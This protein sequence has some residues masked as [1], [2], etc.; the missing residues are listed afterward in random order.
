MMLVQILLCLL[1]G[2]ALWKIWRAFDGESRLIRYLVLAGFASRAIFGSILYWVSFLELPFARSLQLDYGLWFFALDGRTYFRAASDVAAA[3]PMAILLYPRT[4]ISA[5]YVQALSIFTYLFGNVASVG[6]LLNLFCYL[7]M[8]LIIVKWMKVAHASQVPGTVALAAITL[9]PSAMLWSMVP[10]KDTLFQ[11]LVVSI[12]AAGA[13]W[14]RGWRE[15]PR[16]GLILASAAIMAIG[17]FGIAGIRWYFSLM[18]V[19]A[20]GAFFVLTAITSQRKLPAIAAGLVTVFLLAQALLISASLYV[21]R[22]VAYAIAPWK[23]PG[24]ALETVTVARLRDDLNGAR[25]GFEELGGAT[26]IGIGGSLQRIDHGRTLIPA[27]APVTE[28]D[29]ARLAAASAMPAPAP[30]EPPVEVAEPAEDPPPVVTT[31]IAAEIPPTPPPVTVSAAPVTETQPPPPPAPQPQPPA[32][33]QTAAVVEAPPPPAPVQT[34]AVTEVRP[35][36]PATPA[37]ATPAPA[38][39]APATPAPAAPAPAA[40]APAAPAPPPVETK[41]VAEPVKAP[42]PITEPAPAV[43]TTTTTITTTTTTTTQPPVVAA[44]KPQKKARKPK[45]VQPRVVSTPAPAPSTPAPS[46]PAPTVAAAPT[47]APAPAPVPPKKEAIVVPA[48]TFGRIVAGMVAVLVPS[49]VARK[50]E[51]LQMGGG[52]GLWWF[53]DLDTLVFDAV[54]LFAIVFTF[55]RWRWATLRNP[56]FWLVAI[57]ACIGL[58]LIYTVTNYGTLFRL[59]SMMYVTM[60]LIPLALSMAPAY[61][62]ESETPADN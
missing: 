49:A 29:S 28:A 41:P 45:P 18:A 59:R 60:A 2:F 51:L 37:P 25:T 8:C 62:K 1:A 44:K 56:I 31:T 21:P 22:Y 36:A 61:D 40:P 3:G 26:S 11:F 6:L 42:E 57:V 24:D 30:Q 58:P 33:V 34:A 35:P 55:R 47:V 48:S 12:L 39:P 5:S 54:I 13:M 46:T 19:I 52:R 43:T 17:I 10:L 14:Q 4:G 50:L 7:G 38:T 32:P 15:R 27:D 53:T 23:A 16:I 9:L 20:L